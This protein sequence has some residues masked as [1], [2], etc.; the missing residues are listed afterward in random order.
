MLLENS[1]VAEFLKIHLEMVMN[2][3]FSTYTCK[4]M[5]LHLWDK[6]VQVANDHL[7]GFLFVGLFL[8]LKAT[9]TSLTVEAMGKSLGFFVF[10]FGYYSSFLTVCGI[11]DE[12]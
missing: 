3:S 9:L 8:T 2:H 11:A 1:E 10:V 7:C 4:T 6:H 5:V 12:T